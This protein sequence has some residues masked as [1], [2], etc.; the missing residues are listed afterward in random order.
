MMIKIL[1]AKDL[2]YLPDRGKQ[3]LFEYMN[4]LERR[5]ETLLGM[6]YIFV[7]ISMITLLVVFSETTPNNVPFTSVTNIVITVVAAIIFSLSVSFLVYLRKPW[8]YSFYNK[9]V[10]SARLFFLQHFNMDVSKLTPS[11]IWHGVV[12]DRANQAKVNGSYLT[13]VQ[14]SGDASEKTPNQN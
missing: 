2:T 5:H 13:F 6:A 10:L 12:V 8:K 14:Q 7:W 11:D 9:R 3:L 1:T 4:D